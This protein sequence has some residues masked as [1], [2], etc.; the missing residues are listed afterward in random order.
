M[1]GSDLNPPELAEAIN[2]KG[3]MGAAGFRIVA[4]K[5]GHA[6]IALAR[7]DDLLQFFGHFHGGIITALADHAAGIAV[8]SACPKAGSASP[9]R[10][11]SISSAPPTASNSSP[12]PKP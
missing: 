1:T 3:F 6:E 4:I 11:R 9:S 2:A 10:S 7:R 8:T 5:P 12:A